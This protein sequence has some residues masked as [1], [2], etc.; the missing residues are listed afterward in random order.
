MHRGPPERLDAL[1]QG[2]QINLEAGWSE[3]TW[4][5]YGSTWRQFQFYRSQLPEGLSMDMQVM[6]FIE[7]C[8]TPQTD[9]KTGQ[10]VPAVSFRSADIYLRRL[11]SILHQEEVHL[12]TVVRMY[13]R[14]LRRRSATDE[15]NQAPPMTK[16]AMYRLRD[17]VPF[18]ERMELLL[19]WK[20]AARWSD[21]Q[22]VEMRHLQP[23]QG[24]RWSL[25][26]LL[27]KGDPFGQGTGLMLA[28]DPEQDMELHTFKSSRMPREKLVQMTYP[29][30]LHLLTMVDPLQKYTEHSI[31]RGALLCLMTAG[32]PPATMMLIAKHSDI[33]QLM[34]YLPTTEAVESFYRTT[35]ATSYL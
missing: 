16:D 31:K 27:H 24:R 29:R 33:R 2:I 8:V 19:M 20:S 9:V 1:V 35:E 4:A 15:V 10:P 23:G 21:F 26:T 18:N 3:A 12:S 6:C 30:L 32:V 25:R 7:S 14:G 11:S 34:R 13:R 5:G 28:V 17:M 22:A